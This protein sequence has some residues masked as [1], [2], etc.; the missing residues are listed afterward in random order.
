VDGGIPIRGEM[1][2]DV[3][4]G[5]PAFVQCPAGGWI[6]KLSQKQ[7]HI[8]GRGREYAGLLDVVNG[9][10][11]LVEW[12]AVGLCDCFWV[13]CLLGVCSHASWFFCVEGGWM[14]GEVMDMR[15]AVAWVWNHGN[16]CVVVVVVGVWGLASVFIRGEHVMGRIEY[17]GAYASNPGNPSQY[18]VAQISDV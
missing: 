13:G 15:G 1:C 8:G 3:R 7:T 2:A 11:G 10:V 6:P 14:A 17:D 5:V 4:T 18:P 16:F 12:E 9:L